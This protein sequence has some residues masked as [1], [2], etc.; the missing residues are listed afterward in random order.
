[1]EGCLFGRP[2]C[3]T[4]LFMYLKVERKA[5]LSFG[6]KTYLILCLDCSREQ[7]RDSFA[8][9]V[10]PEP[11]DHTCSPRCKRWASPVI[12]LKSPG[13]R[14]SRVVASIVPSWWT[15]HTVAAAGRAGRVGSK[16]QWWWTTHRWSV[17]VGQVNSSKRKTFFFES[18]D[19]ST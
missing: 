7:P 6:G 10:T 4:F 11:C 8:K 17:W 12:G 16:G 3:S 9:D 14:P 5:N 19:H 2:N 15:T 13:P 18:I 1:M